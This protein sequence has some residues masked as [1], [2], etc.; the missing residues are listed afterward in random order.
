M[1]PI[2]R[3]NNRDSNRLSDRIINGSD[4]LF[5]QLLC[6]D[7]VQKLMI[8]GEKNE[9]NVVIAYKRFKDGE[10]YASD[11]VLNQ[12]LKNCLRLTDKVEEQQFFGFCIDGGLWYLK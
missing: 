7:F 8:C 10:E 2:F 6:D 3:L 4:A 5:Q 11:Q 9:R 1:E 12:A